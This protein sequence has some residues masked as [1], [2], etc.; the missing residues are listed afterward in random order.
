MKII[1]QKEALALP[2]IFLQKD[3]ET[4]KKTTKKQQTY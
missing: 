2:L 1:G 4:T 3:V